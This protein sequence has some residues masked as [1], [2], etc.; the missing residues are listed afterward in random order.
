M[1]R[2]ELDVRQIAPQGCRCISQFLIGG[3]LS[4]TEVDA[5][6]S[7]LG[8]TAGL[9]GAAKDVAATLPTTNGIMARSASSLS[10]VAFTRIFATRVSPLLLANEEP[11]ARRLAHGANQFVAC[12]PAPSRDA[13]VGSRLFADDL[14]YLTALRLAQPA[15]NERCQ[16]AAAGLTEVNGRIRRQR[17]SCA[18]PLHLG[19]LKWRQRSR[20]CA[21]QTSR[22]RPIFRGQLR[23]L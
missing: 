12:E 8:G 2:C 18:T 20:A 22:K 21:V 10:C 19:V 11:R 17:S 13:L 1:R 6:G 23:R 14:E 15:A 5:E 9:C 3:C 4:R 16:I 7:V